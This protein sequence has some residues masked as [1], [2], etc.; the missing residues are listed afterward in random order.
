MQLLTAQK[1]KL[2]RVNIVRT[3]PQPTDAVY[4]VLQVNSNIDN[5]DAVCHT[6]DDLDD[7][8]CEEDSGDD[9]QSARTQ[10]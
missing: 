2:L 4:Y 3:C 1:I 8:I 5:I 9:E 6:D 10:N 7:E